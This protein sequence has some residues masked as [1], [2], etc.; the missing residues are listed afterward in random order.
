MEI[1]SNEGIPALPPLP[2]VATDI[3]APGKGDGQNW[4]L[5]SAGIAV[6]AVATP[7]SPATLDEDEST[8]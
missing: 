6:V 7:Q 8:E 2:W 4:P 3:H 1:V 5:V